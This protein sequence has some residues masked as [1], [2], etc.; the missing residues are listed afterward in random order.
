M[1][2]R[3]RRPRPVRAGAGE[4]RLTLR[5]VQRLNQVGLASEMSGPAGFV[6]RQRELRVLEEKLSEARTGHPQVVY[7]EADPGAGK[8]TLLSKFAASITDALVLEVGADED[9]TLLAFGVIDQLLSGVPTDPGTDPM[10]V[11]TGW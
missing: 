7:L 2:D 5:P 9:E 11:G 4:V 1:Q 10:A 6:G 8:S 3:S